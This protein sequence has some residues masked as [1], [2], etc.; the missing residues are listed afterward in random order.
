MGTPR[1]QMLLGLKV[2]TFN[3]K[4]RINSD[5]SAA[6]QHYSKNT[7]KFQLYGL[8][9]ESHM[10]SSCLYYVRVH[11]EADLSEDVRA[12]TY[13]YHVRIVYVYM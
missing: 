7:L 4:T 6:S 11:V 5:V 13:I 12:L 3:S 10:H 9:F 8:C 2:K 1:Y